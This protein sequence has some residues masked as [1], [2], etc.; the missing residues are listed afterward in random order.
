M[1]EARRS[2]VRR[3]VVGEPVDVVPSTA[4]TRL[5]PEAPEAPAPLADSD[6]ASVRALAAA[7]GPAAIAALVKIINEGTSETARI[8]AANALL[9]RGFG[10]GRIG[11]D[12]EPPP[13]EQTMVVVKFV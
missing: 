1:T 10:K 5:T 11:G 6:P 7:Q 13:Q 4:T 8:A 9:D 3:K 2:G 12:F